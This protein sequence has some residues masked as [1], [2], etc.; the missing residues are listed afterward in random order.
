[1][2]KILPLFGQDP[3]ALGHN[4]DVNLKRIAAVPQVVTTKIKITPYFAAR[5]QAARCHTSQIS[6]SGPRFPDFLSKWLFQFDMYTRIVPPFEN[7][8]IERDLFAGVGET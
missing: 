1:M 8:A 7:G 5:Q 2:V 3:A 4:K 6:T